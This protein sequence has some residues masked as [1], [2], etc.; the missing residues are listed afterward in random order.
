[1]CYHILAVILRSMC[2]K[3]VDV[4]LVMILEPVENTNDILIF[5]CLLLYNIRIILVD[6]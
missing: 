6:F 3:N 4:Q 2:C 1:V 5:C